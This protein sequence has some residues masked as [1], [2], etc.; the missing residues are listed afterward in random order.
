MEQQLQQ[1]Q[2]RMQVMMAEVQ[3]LSA[4]KEQLK[5]QAASSAA[6]MTGTVMQMQCRV[7]KAAD[8]M[9]VKIGGISRPTSTLRDMKDLGETVLFNNV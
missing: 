6:A 9:G 2:Q 3:R 8:A 1:M 7:V 5:Q 4:E